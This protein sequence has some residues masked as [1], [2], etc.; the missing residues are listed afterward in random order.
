M[1]SFKDNKVWD[2]GR[3]ICAST[4]RTGRVS[5]LPIDSKWV[6]RVYRCAGVESKD[7]RFSWYGLL[8]ARASYAQHRLNPGSGV[9]YDCVFICIWV[10][11][12]IYKI[13][14]RLKQWGHGMF[15]FLRKHS[16]P[17]VGPPTL[18][19]SLVGSKLLGPPLISVSFKTCHCYLVIED[20]MSTI[21]P[22]W[23]PKLDGSILIWPKM[24]IHWCL[25]FLP[26]LY[27][28]VDYNDPTTTSP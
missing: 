3:S 15:I 8:V 25:L 20:A 23:I 27:I 28:W 2:F 4:T 21:D 19:M 13:S 10:T 7:A 22:R 17:I 18:A 12:K 14:G 5:D 9:A 26:C 16:E 6:D 11:D 24:P 1:I